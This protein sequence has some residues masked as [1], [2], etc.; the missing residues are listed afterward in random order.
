MPDPPDKNT[1]YVAKV[2]AAEVQKISSLTTT[3][4]TVLLFS[5]KIKM[6]ES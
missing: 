4:D 5:K 1:T 6:L 2:I 3:F